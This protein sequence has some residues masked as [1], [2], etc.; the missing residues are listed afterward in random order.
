M[1]FQYRNMIRLLYY[2]IG[3][4][5]IAHQMMFVFI[6]FI[7]CWLWYLYKAWLKQHTNISY[8]SSKWSYMLVISYMS[9]FINSKNLYKND[10]F[11]E[12]DVYCIDARFYGNVSR[13]INHRCD[14]NI[15]PVRVFI[16]HQ[17]L[18]FPRIAFFASRDIRAYEE[19]G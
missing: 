9:F 13:F 6:W 2:L 10:S 4:L 19:L 8:H 16:D 3:Y 5:G 14:P 18:R 7:I 11:Q 12:G 15:V 17:D 1:I